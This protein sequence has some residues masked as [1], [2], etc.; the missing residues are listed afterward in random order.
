MVG[1]Q[2][3][4]QAELIDDDSELKLVEKYAKNGRFSRV[5]IHPVARSV[6]LVPTS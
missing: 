2:Q 3:D 6:S 1:Y 4:W 5:L